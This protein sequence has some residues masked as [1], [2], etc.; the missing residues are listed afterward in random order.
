VVRWYF[1]QCQRSGKLASTPLGVVLSS[2]ETASQRI[3]EIAWRTIG[4]VDDVDAR[5]K[6][7]SCAY[8]DYFVVGMSSYD[9]DAL[10]VFE[11]R[12]ARK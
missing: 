4:S 6:R 3:G 10:G 9:D 8:A 2:C 11:F 5:E 7:K 1:R 12:Q